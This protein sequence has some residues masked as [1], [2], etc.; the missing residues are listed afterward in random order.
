MSVNF[1][2]YVFKF[3]PSAPRF[4]AF[5]TDFVGLSK[6]LCYADFEENGG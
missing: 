6:L 2:C 3:A 4:P 1:L 5:H